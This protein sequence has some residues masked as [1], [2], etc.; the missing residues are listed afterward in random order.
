MR[1]AIRISVGGSSDDGENG[2]SVRRAREGGRQQTSNAAAFAAVRLRFGSVAAVLL[3]ALD[4]A[5]DPLERF[6]HSTFNSY[7]LLL[8]RLVVEIVTDSLRK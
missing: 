7:L 4:V 1:V 5:C 8:L 6:W 3:V 2:I